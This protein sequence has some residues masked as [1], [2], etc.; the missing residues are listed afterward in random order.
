MI[1]SPASWSSLSVASP[2]PSS[3]SC[4]ATRSRSGRPSRYALWLGLIALAAGGSRSP[5]RQFLGRGAGVAIA[6]AIMFGGWLLNGYQGAVP[7]LAPFANLTWFGWTTNHLPLA[8]AFD[9]PSLLPVALPSSSSSSIGVEAF[10]R[11]DIGATSAVPTPSLPHAL[12]GLSGPAGRAFGNGLPTALAWGLGLGIFG[13]VMAGS[14]RPSPTLVKTSPEL[15]RMLQSV[16][17]GADI[18]SVG[19]FLQLLFVEFGLILAGLAAATLVGAWASDETSGRLEMLLATP[20]A[21]ARWVLAGGVAILGQIAVFTLIAAL[22]IAIG[23]RDDRGR[24]R[25]ADRGDL[26]PGRVRGRLSGIGL[27]SAGSGGRAGPRRPWR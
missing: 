21:R 15:A 25:G 26:R 7:A 10:V 1:T 8:G 4:Q 12:V 3:A 19:G 22:G 23:T 5:C 9:W 6:G 20:L 13:F 2:A 14:G 11:R 27:R 16:F 17:P 18:L 24:C